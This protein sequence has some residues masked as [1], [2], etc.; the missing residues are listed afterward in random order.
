MKG[1]YIAAPASLIGSALVFVVLRFLFS[2]RLRRWS[3]SSE[4][5]QALEEV[6]VSGIDHIVG[7]VLTPYFQSAKGLPLIFLIRASPF[8]P[9]VYANS[10]F[11]VSILGPVTLSVADSLYG[12]S[13]EAVSL[14]QFMAA[15]TVV[16]PKLALHVF[17]GSRL[18]ALS[19][20][21]T[22]RQ[23]DTRKLRVHA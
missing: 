17:V 18:A 16:F 23:M 19:D 9:W 1:W 15:T 21:E 4:K 5:W 3:S 22:R 11:A 2:K 10:L 13:I 6:V 7:F 8:P 12:Q 14:W 20:G